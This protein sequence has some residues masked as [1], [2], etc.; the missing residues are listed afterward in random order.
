MPQFETRKVQITGGGSSYII[1]LPKKWVEEHKIEKN[2]PIGI[3]I[4][5]DGTLLI[6]TK[7]IG[8]QSRRTKE[9]DVTNITDQKYLF[10]LLI[11]A[12]I[13]GYS[14][15]EIKSAN[16]ID[17][18]LRECISNF[19]LAT[20]GP[21]I[22]DETIKSITIKNLINPTEM[23]FPNTLNRMYLLTKSMHIDA[24][25][26][27]EVEDTAMAFEVAN[28]DS[29]VDRL[30]W[31]IA[32]QANLVMQDT[33]LSKEML[34]T[35]EQANYY[36]VISRIIERIGDHAVKIAENVPIII[37][38]GLNKEIVKKIVNASNLA[39][40]IFTNSINAWTSQNI[41]KA[42]ETINSISRLVEDCEAIHNDAIQLKGEPTIAVSYI[43]E[44]IRR[45]GEYAVDISEVTINF[46]VN[47]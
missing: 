8:D 16:E 19:T 26:A 33:I 11:G 40:S 28:R 5:S 21:E 38:K 13:M 22:M 14:I 10:R 43:I 39:L 24:I 7:K 3:L 18:S 20:I 1:T 25:K 32:R 45:T 36:F 46:L 34:V 12:Y 31:L 2:D 6:T 4:Q 23:P 41:K 9:I 44:S 29:K 17:S 27:L 30:H 42:N 15:I 37:E 35:P 47:G